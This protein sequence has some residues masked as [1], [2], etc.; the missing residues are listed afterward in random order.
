[1]NPISLCRT[2]R[3]AGVLVALLLAAGASVGASEEI[4]SSQDEPGESV[5]PAIISEPFF[6]DLPAIR[7]RGILRAL[8][9]FSR[10]DFFLEGPRPRGV[11]VE[12]LDIYRAHLN[13]GRGSGQL[14]VAIKYVVVPFADLLPALLDGRGDIAVANLTLTPEREAIVDFAAGAHGSV[15]EL[16]VTHRS[17]ND[18]RSLEDLAGR[19]IVVLAGSSYAEHLHALNRLF[20]AEGLATIEIREAA[21]ELA[22]EDLLEMVNSGVIDMTVADDYRALLWQRVLADV[23]VREDV[24]INT[25][26]TLGWAVR[27]GNPELLASLREIATELKRGTLIGNTLINRYY[28]NTRWITNPLA[29]AKRRKYERLAG[30][31]R[32]YGEQYDINWRALAAQAYQ[33]SGLDQGAEG[34][35][36]ARGIMQLLPSTAA[37]PNVG[38]A[39]IDGIDDNIHAGARYMAFLRDHYFSDEGI[40][41]WDQLAFAWAAYNAGPARVARMRER[42]RS[43]GFDPNRWFGHVEHAAF[44]VAGLGPVRYVRNVYRYYLTYLMIEEAGG[45]ALGSPAPPAVGD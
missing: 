37:D 15:D 10:T 11:F 25:G 41:E 17:V 23:V 40:E 35:N 24:A 32:K 13:E 19:R 4:P 30:I 3:A 27:K 2:G 28:D 26:G 6:G 45:D 31:F 36:G 44:A 8:V 22:T 42:A 33:E 7:E 38:I 34:P 43:L 12:M 5:V 1:M 29:D 20:E 16:L 18:V 21:S 39:N 14:P 9:S